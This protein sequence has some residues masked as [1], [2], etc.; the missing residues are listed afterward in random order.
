MKSVTP[1]ILVLAALLQT[2]AIRGVSIK[3]GHALS[4]TEDG[5]ATF[6]VN[7]AEHAV[8]DTRNQQKA[9]GNIPHTLRN[10]EMLKEKC[11][12]HSMLCSPSTKEGCKNC[13]KCTMYCNCPSFE[14]SLTRCKKRVET[15]KELSTNQSP[16]AKKWAVHHKINRVY[17]GSLQYFA[18]HFKSIEP[19]ELLRLLLC[20]GRF[21]IVTNSFDALK[22]AYT[23]KNSSFRMECVHTNSIAIC[24]LFL[25]DFYDG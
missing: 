1:L 11:D 9:T 14:A 23:C 21:T 4:S 7:V 8:E 22:Q 6:G 20:F 15:C 24:I 5:P 12:E 19:I 16:E 25:G 10:N 2:S 18:F 17:T 13:Q 3:A